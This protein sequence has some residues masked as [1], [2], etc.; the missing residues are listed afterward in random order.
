MSEA[1]PEEERERGFP[2]KKV[3]YAIA[4]LLCLFPFVCVGLLFWGLHSPPGIIDD[5][6]WCQHEWGAE[7]IVDWTECDGWD[8]SSGQM[9]YSRIQGTGVPSLELCKRMQG[10]E[11]IKDD[12]RELG[13]TCDVES[14]SL[15][16]R[17]D[18]D[19]LQIDWAQ[20]CVREDCA[21][22][23]VTLSRVLAFSEDCRRVS[24]IAA[25]NSDPLI[26]EERA[27]QS[28]CNT[29]AD[30]GIDDG[31]CNAGECEPPSE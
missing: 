25:R 23:E 6:F 31:V 3:L 29:N 16:H 26:D 27:R 12:T 11:T 14:P 5:P 19:Q 15:W 2:F 9:V 21:N 1:V 28:R 22:H 7:S 24:A 4:I 20:T 17:I 10:V 13:A 18:C 8:W 30:C